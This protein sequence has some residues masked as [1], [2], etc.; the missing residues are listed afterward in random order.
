M[1][2]TAWIV[3]AILIAICGLIIYSMVRDRKSGKHSSC[4]G[5]TAC[6]AGSC[7]TCGSSE[8]MAAE[9]RAKLKQGEYANELKNKQDTKEN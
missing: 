2:L 6:S 5:C 7:S 8:H 1:N 3:L 9:I 4:N